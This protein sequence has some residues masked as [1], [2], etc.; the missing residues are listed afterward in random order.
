MQLDPM[1]TGIV[2]IVAALIV[3]ALVVWMAARRR[4]EHDLRDRTDRASHADSFQVRDLSKDQKERYAGEWERIE[5]RFV[6]RPT[7]AVMEADELMQ[8]I[9]RQKGYPVR[10]FDRLLEDIA[11][12]QPELVDDFRASHE[13]IDSDKPSDLTTE[14]L[15]K[16]MLHYRNLYDRLVGPV[17]RETAARSDAEVPLATATKSD[18]TDQV[19]EPEP[20]RNSER[21]R[22]LRDDR[23]R[24][25]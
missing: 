2:V 22:P 5:T 14:Q 18:E 21:E 3:I 7:A 19:R 8:E 6:E 23:P 9:L 25:R 1:L 12:Q 4:K 16:A 11:V 20:R 10:A 15:R 13:V 24:L 17:P